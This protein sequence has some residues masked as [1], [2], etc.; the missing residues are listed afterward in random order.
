MKDAKHWSNNCAGLF[1]IAMVFF[2][3]T[4]AIDRFSPTQATGAVLFL[5]GA[6]GLVALAGWTWFALKAGQGS[7]ES[8][9]FSR[10]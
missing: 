8:V 9:L 4:I 10:R 5:F 3:V 1:L 6:I 7:G 2:A